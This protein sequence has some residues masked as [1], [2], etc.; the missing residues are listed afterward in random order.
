MRSTVRRILIVGVTFSL[1]IAC[2]HTGPC[3][4]EIGKD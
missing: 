1:T 2:F 4:N 3:S